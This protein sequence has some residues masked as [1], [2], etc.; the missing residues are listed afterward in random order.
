MHELSVCLS[1]LDQVERIAQEHGAERVERIRLRIGPL[2]GVEAPLLAN[3]YPLAAA[4]TL[5]EHAELEI[6]AAPVRVHCVDC[7]QESEASANRLLCAG[8]G[9]YHTRLTSGD[10]MLLASLEMSIPDQL[11]ADADEDGTSA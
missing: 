3:A 10:E 11:D 1:L 4:G 9:S 5:A 7:G 6:E 2:S 8:C